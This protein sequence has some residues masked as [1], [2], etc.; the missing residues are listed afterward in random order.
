MDLHEH[1]RVVTAVVSGG[2]KWQWGVIRQH[3]HILSSGDAFSGKAAMTQEPATKKQ[4]DANIQYMSGGPHVQQYIDRTLALLANAD[5]GNAGVF[6]H[7]MLP[8]LT[9]YDD[10]FAW[11]RTVKPPEEGSDESGSGRVGLRQPRLGTFNRDGVVARGGVPVISEKYELGGGGH[12]LRVES[13][14]VLWRSVV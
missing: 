9:H 4:T 8:L 14:C 11:C 13:C 6:S 10:M 5:T 1:S 7:S 2:C 12:G 3:G